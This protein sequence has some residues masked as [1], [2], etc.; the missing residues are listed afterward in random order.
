M[1]ANEVDFDALTAFLDRLSNPI[2]IP[3]SGRYDRETLAKLKQISAQYPNDKF[4]Y[5]IGKSYKNGKADIYLEF[6][7]DECHKVFD[8]HASKTMFVDFLLSRKEIDGY[9]DDCLSIRKQEE[10][11]KNKH[12][13]EKYEAEYQ[14]KLQEKYDIF[15]NVYLNGSMSWNK[16]IKAYE[17]YQELNRVFPHGRE[18]EIALQIR[19]LPYDAFLATPYWTGISHYAKQRA[20]YRCKLC[21]QNNDLVTHHP[22]YDIHGYELQ[23]ID[24][25]T[26]I[27]RSC[28]EIFHNNSYADGQQKH[29]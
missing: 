18:N 20:K 1:K 17:K 27:C 2:L 15:I 24:E 14:K 16:G 21:S 13:I 12:L 25:L 10:K 7:C 28:H 3:A 4:S 29:V 22:T 9:C 26:V 6:E 11:E 5:A 8:L 19:S 23:K